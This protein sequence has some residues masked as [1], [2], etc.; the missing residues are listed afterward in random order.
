M[1]EFVC[2][3]GSVP[4]INANTPDIFLDDSSDLK[5][6]LKNIQGRFIIPNIKKVIRLRK[7]LTLS[8]IHREVSQ[9]TF[10]FDLN[11]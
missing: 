11:L 8:L 10:P 7:E 6:S 1:E 9:Q 5:L 3:F 2:E 4:F